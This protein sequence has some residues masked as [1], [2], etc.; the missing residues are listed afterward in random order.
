MTTI[1]FDHIV[2]RVADQL[3]TAEA[4]GHS[5]NEVAAAAVEQA[6]TARRDAAAQ[7]LYGRKRETR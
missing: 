5:I 7:A 3:M 2:R 1:D 6:K 4:N